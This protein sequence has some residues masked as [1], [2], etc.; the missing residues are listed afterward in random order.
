MGKLIPNMKKNVEHPTHYNDCSVDCIT[1]MECAFGY[2]KTAIFALL[3]AF[4]Y[5]WRHKQKNGLEDLYKARW[6]LDYWNT[7]EKVHADDAPA[8]YADKKPYDAMKFNVENFIKGAEAEQK[9]EKQ[10]Q[11]F[12][13]LKMNPDLDPHVYND[14]FYD[15]DWD[16]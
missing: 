7:L 5:L 8:I 15:G 3:N 2:E 10:S 12:D 13:D 9:V 6:Y 11:T 16:D 1:A 14:D 4:K